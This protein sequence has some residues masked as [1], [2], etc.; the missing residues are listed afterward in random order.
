MTFLEFNKKFPTEKAAI[1]YFY[2]SIAIIRSG[3]LVIQKFLSTYIR[4]KAVSSRELS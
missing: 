2:K 4:G 1:D 3:D